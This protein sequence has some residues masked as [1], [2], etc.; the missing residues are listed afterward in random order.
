MWE[1]ARVWGSVWECVG[2]YGSLGVCES[3]RWCSNMWEYVGVY[4]K[5]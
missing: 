3:E 5:V 2:V 1:E 4:E